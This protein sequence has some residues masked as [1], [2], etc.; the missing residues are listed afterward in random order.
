MLETLKNVEATDAST[1]VDMRGTEA[2]F[3]DRAASSDGPRGFA[4][5]GSADRVTVV[6]DPGTPIARVVPSDKKVL[7][8][9]PRRAR[10]V[11]SGLVLAGRRVHTNGAAAMVALAATQAERS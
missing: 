5:V 7:P 4:V 2:P 3:A 6:A 8:A 11:W 9:V 1:Y 10:P